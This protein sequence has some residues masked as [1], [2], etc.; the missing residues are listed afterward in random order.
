MDMTTKNGGF[1]RY[2]ALAR[3][4]FPAWSRAA[5]A[6]WVLAKMKAPQ[7]KVPISTGWCHDQRAY[8]FERTTR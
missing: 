4:L 6:R 7:P 8:R 3:E 5:R 1:A 2:R